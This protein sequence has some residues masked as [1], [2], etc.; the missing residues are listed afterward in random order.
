MKAIE[1]YSEAKRQFSDQNR[2][3]LINVQ[4]PHQWVSTLK[5]AVFGMSPSLSPLIN[6]G[7]ELHGG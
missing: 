4:T 7:G 5:S 6:E 3:V 1:T 2:A